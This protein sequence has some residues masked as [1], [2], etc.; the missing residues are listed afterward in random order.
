MAQILIAAQF[1]LDAVQRAMAAQAPAPGAIRLG[2][3]REEQCL[4]EIKAAAEWATH[5]PF[6]GPH[7]ALSIDELRAI[8]EYLEPKPRQSV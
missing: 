8:E 3:G 5:Y 1:A 2:G 7:I 6:A 4:A